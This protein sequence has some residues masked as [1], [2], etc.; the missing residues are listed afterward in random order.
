MP[1]QKESAT[2]WPG[3]QATRAA[4]ELTARNLK[5]VSAEGELHP[6]SRESGTSKGR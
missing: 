1:K 6:M 4:R 5:W 3:Y 2:A